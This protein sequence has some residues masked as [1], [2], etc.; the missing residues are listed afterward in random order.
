VDDLRETQSAHITSLVSEANE[1]IGAIARLNPK[2][3]EFEG[4]GSLPSDAGAE[5]SQRYAAMNRLAEIMPV[6]FRENPNGTVDVFSGP[7]YLILGNTTQRLETFSTVD[8]GSTVQG[9]RLSRTGSDVTL[10]GGELRG[11]AE[12]RDEI[13]GGFVDQLDALAGNLISEFNRLHSSGEGL[14]GFQSVS[15]TNRVMDTAA[16][17]SA[18][19]L[20]F[21]PTHGSFQLKVQ[22]QQTGLADTTTI[23]VDLDGIGT[24]TSLDDLR[25]ALDAVGNVTASVDSLG[26]LQIQAA[27]GYELRFGED[28]SGVLASL[29]INTFFQGSDSATIGVN[30]AVQNDARL[31]AAGRGGGLAD[32]QNVSQMVDFFDQPLEGL[33][34]RSVV[35]H[36]EYVV[37]DVAQRSAAESSLAKGLGTFRQSLES[38]RAQFSSVSL[39]EEAVKLIQFQQAYQSAARVISTTD[40][41]MQT[42]LNL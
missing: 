2:I 25:A 10:L 14:V 16:P 40:E 33:D 4:G 19:G 18:A 35:G 39:D 42:L 27:D 6:R 23:A 36:Y 32:G 15:A 38:Q 34:G 26:R 31:F 7:E 5:R 12:G 21:P 11:T 24:D 8:R 41:L 37:A 29:G 3:A 9:V 20:D 30:A 17:L 13:L 22:N 1:L 28:T